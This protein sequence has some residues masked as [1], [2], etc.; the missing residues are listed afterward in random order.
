MKKVFYMNGPVKQKTCSQRN[1]PVKQKTCFAIEASY[2][3]R[4][5]NEL[6]GGIPG[7]R[8]QWQMKAARNYRSRSFCESDSESQKLKAA[9]RR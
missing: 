2:I 4:I 8:C 1:R 7:R 6:F 5:L 9:R 3:K